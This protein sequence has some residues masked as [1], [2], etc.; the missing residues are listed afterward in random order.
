[1]ETL[2]VTSPI[3]V[4]LC[5]SVS[6]PG[7]EPCREGKWKALSC[8]CKLNSHYPLAPSCSLRPFGYLFIWHQQDGAL[9]LFVPVHTA[10]QKIWLYWLW[11][12]QK[13]WLF[14]IPQRMIYC[15]YASKLG[16][17]NNSWSGLLF[18][19]AVLCPCRATTTLFIHHNHF[20]II[21]SLQC[22]PCHIWFQVCSSSRKPS[23][24]WGDADS[25]IFMFI[26]SGILCLCVPGSSVTQM[27]FWSR[28]YWAEKVA[29]M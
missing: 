29:R 10:S 8:T 21:S 27:H 14:K 3:V 16:D 9:G 5:D 17:A 2:W 15:S 19:P 18:F 25:N 24:M 12:V 22:S 7:V 13:P 26:F 28:L 20:V 6:P 23:H 4:D 1:M 11:I